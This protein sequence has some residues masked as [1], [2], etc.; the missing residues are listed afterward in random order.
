MNGLRPVSI[1]A[2]TRLRCLPKPPRP[3]ARIPRR[4][5]LS[6]Y[7]P[8]HHKH[9]LARSA[10]SPVSTPLDPSITGLTPISL[11]NRESPIRCLLAAI[12]ARRDPAIWHHF[13]AVTT[14]GLTPHL[15]AADF[16]SIL[17]SLRPARYVSLKARHH[18]NGLGNPRL[19]PLRISYDEFRRRLHAVSIQMEANGYKMGVHEYTHLLDCARAGKDRSLAEQLWRSMAAAG[20]APDTRTYNS[21][22][23]ALCGTATSERE[24]RITE[25]TLARRS[26]RPED[27]RTKAVRI[28]RSMIDR[29]V[30]P[31]S[32]TFD[33]LLL[34]MSRMGDVGGM[35][36]TLKEVW[37]VDVETLATGKEIPPPVVG[38]DSP[39][40]PTQHTLLAVAA[41]FGS[42]NDVES[43]VR[44]VD[45][46]ARRYDVKISKPT[47]AM[48]L[49]WTYVATR[50]PAMYLPNYSP[51]N[52]WSIMTAPPYSAAPTIEMYDY[53]VR[54]LIA[55]R[56]HEKAIVT[57]GD[58]LKIYAADIAA[59]GH[60]DR[61]MKEIA[62]RRRMGFRG[63]SM[64]RRWAELLCLGKGMKPGYART[65]VPDVVR[66]LGWFLGDKVTYVMSTGY[67][68]LERG[69]E[70]AWRPM[71]IRRR[72]R[73]WTP[74]GTGSKE[75]DYL[76]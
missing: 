73:M 14:A 3:S 33:L 68:T 16:S 32:M 1:R 30:V 4:Y 10:P 12:S 18:L 8:L 35:W 37:G 39:L 61:D 48:L 2:C 56:M 29:G 59:N 67:V 49:N 64:V 41:A 50:P 9:L 22:M 43:A 7:G 58:A 5:L 21:Y 47:W 27:V 75:M 26:A 51:V 46:L 54:S 25:L 23:A 20:V 40:C 24:L 15:T 65:L 60:I 57:I 17:L 19:L 72:K 6:G 45:H 28:Y 74:L 44:V 55:R 66:K 42:N 63:R 38:K 76:D 69:K 13:T 36:R 71:S 52:L 70:Y 31:N 62:W 34:A 11:I 53:L